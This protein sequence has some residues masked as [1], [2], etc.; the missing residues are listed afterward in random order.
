MKTT[1][2]SVGL[3]LK[4]TVLAVFCTGL[5]LLRASE[6][7]TADAKPKLVITPAQVDFK[8]KTKVTLEGSGF[9][10]KQELGIEVEMGGSPS[11]VSY[12]LKPR[13]VA[14]EKGQFK[15]E[16]VLDGEIK[17]LEPKEHKITVVDQ[18]GKVLT[19]GTL[20]FKKPEPKAKKE[21][22]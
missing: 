4:V 22:K 13:P 11:D 16:W 19:T 2:P 6:S 12:L 18:D 9:K 17:L 14:D 15:S 20:A 1:K 7:Q 10:P 3:L 21:K 8:P 5:F